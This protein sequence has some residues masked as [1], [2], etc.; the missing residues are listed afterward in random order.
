MLR[1]AERGIFRDAGRGALRVQR[2]LPPARGVLPPGPRRAPRARAG[3]GHG[4]VMP[5]L[6]NARSKTL[7]FVAFGLLLSVLTALIV[8]GLAR[9]E[10]FNRQIHALTEA[11]GRKIGVVSELFLA[12]GQR[13]ESI[14]K[15][16]AADTQPAREATLARY[17]GA[18]AAYEGAV[19]K[20]RGLD[21]GGAERDARDAA[22]TA[23][24]ASLAIGD[25][26]AALLMQGEVA[27]AS[28]LNLT[29]AVMVD[30]RL[31]ET[32]Y[33]L[34]EANNSQTTQSIAVANEGMRF[35]FLLLGAGGLLALI[36]GFVIAVLVVRIVTRTEDRL[37]R[38][39]ELAEVTLHSI[40]DGVITTDATGR[41][42]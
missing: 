42:E 4:A 8:I 35:G 2:G 25:K 9:M 23:A 20:L 13:S 17:Q 1:G 12:N 34:L 33:L 7:L 6:A 27:P 21:V 5:S 32:L 31:Q 30:S 26:I 28:E 41:V 36:A 29:Q 10:S 39:K 19:K 15:L 38:E 22:I 11:Q 24:G 18:I 40:V 14:D 16:F 37:E 3:A